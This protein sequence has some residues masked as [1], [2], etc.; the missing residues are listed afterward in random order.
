[1]KNLEEDNL[2][3]EFQLIKEYDKVANL[4]QVKQ[5]DIYNLLEIWN[6][7]TNFLYSWRVND[8]FA[9]KL[10]K[11]REEFTQLIIPSLYRDYV[12][13]LYEKM[14]KEKSYTQKRKIFAESIL[15]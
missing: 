1:M 8:E 13:K 7:N 14:R 10:F 4:S 15:N 12:E 5:R 2:E 6:E 11:F 3:N 9:Q